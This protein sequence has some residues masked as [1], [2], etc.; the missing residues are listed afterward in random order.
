MELSELKAVMAAS[1]LGGT[2]IRE[3]GRVT[4]PDEVEIETAV[5]VAQE[6][7]E[8]VLKQERD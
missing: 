4:V 7:W 5:K 8:E 3:K 6:I 1:L 2:I